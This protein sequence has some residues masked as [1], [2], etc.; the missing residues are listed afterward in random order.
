VRVT[1]RRLIPVVA[2]TVVALVAAEMSVAPTSPAASAARGRHW[3]GVPALLSSD[4]LRAELPSGRQVR[5]A[6]PALPVGGVRVLGD[7]DGDHAETT[8]IFL[9]GQWQLW[10]QVQ[11]LGPPLTTTF[12]QSGDVPIT[13]DW[14]GDGVTDLGVVRGSE[15]ILARGPVRA[16]ENPSVWRRFTFGD[17][18]GVPVSG[19]WDG[20]GTD[21]VGTFSDGTWRLAESVDA[22]RR[23]MT[24]SYGASG[25]R[26]VVGDWDGVDG[27][28]LGVQR[29]STWYLSSSATRPRTTAKRTLAPTADEAPAAWTVANTTGATT[30][31]TS[32]QDRVGEAGWV[33]PS[34]LLDSKVG[35]RVGR[36]GRQVQGSLEESERYLL[37]SQ[38]E[39]KWHATSGAAYLDLLTDG[40]DT[41]EIQVRL[42]AMSAFT[43]AV[44]L[45]TG[46][47]HPARVGASRQAGHRYVDRLVRSIACSHASVSPGGWGRG[48]QT[49][50]WAML[51][52][53]AAWLEWSRLSPQTRVDVTSMVVTEADRLSNRAP[54]YWG[55]RDGTIVTPGD[56]KAEEDAWNAS[57]LAFAAAMMPRAPRAAVWRAQSAQLAVAAYSTRR[58]T[59]SSRVVNGVRLTDRLRGFNAYPDGTVENHQRIHPDY[60]SSV[61]LLWTAAD[62]DRL[63]GRSVPEAM[64]HNGGLVYSAF[65]RHHYVAG[66][67]SPA[68]GRFADP[69]GT[70][71]TTGHSWIYYPQGDDWGTARRAHFLSLD[72]HAKVYARYLHARGWAA[73]QALRWHEAAQRA[74]VASS[75][76]D[77]GRTYSV[78]PSVAAQQDTY[79]GREEYAAQNLATAWLALYVGEL[80]V[81][82]L[83]RSTLAVPGTTRGPAKAPAG[84]WAARLAP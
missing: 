49:A 53:A 72:A 68:G 78:D 2:G 14:N 80:G 45:R 1:R 79:P 83:D 33:V 38:F 24:R 34:S 23:T 59:R 66:A 5:Y 37:N 8:G 40:R 13:G 47:F 69:G 3:V 50:S 51:T 81:S 82:R 65:S 9:D 70:V 35:A 73:D 46:A 39:T 67:A 76:T 77:D 48:W 75:G 54:G 57:M 63:A 12:G 18:T 6:L 62:F 44:G 29:D 15:W 22:P 74:L 25:D 84:R 4:G 43:V 32:T 26:P 55:R 41:D 16:H 58:D 7:W 11:R 42:P 30:C 31:P 36:V 64:F 52:G 60:A 19:D 27:D 56:T 10:D 71:Y 28:G 17:G 21:G 61:Q 20:D